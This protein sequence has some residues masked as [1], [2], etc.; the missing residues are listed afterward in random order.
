METSPLSRM[1]DAGAFGKLSLLTSSLGDQVLLSPRSPPSL[2]IYNWKVVSLEF[3]GCGLN[4]H[5]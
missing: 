3:T 4:R 1:E 5:I 2:Y